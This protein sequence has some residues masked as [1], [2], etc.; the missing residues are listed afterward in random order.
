[1]VISTDNLY[2]IR[3]V[4]RND[5]RFP[6]ELNWPA[7]ARTF[8]R[9][10][11]LHVL[12]ILAVG[13][14]LRWP[15]MALAPFFTTDS[16]CCYYHYAV[17][18]LLAG[19]PFDSDMWFLPGYA[20]FLAAILG[21]TGTHTFA[22]VLIQHLLGLATGLLVY[23]IGRHLFHP[24]VGLLAALATVLDVELALFE[25]EI[26]PETLF[27]FLM[28][29]VIC[30][31]VFGLERYH[32]SAAVF[33][34]VVAGVL[35]MVRPAG[36]IFAAVVVVAPQ[37]G[38]LGT[39]A[40]VIIAASAGL[41]AVLLPVMVY[42][43]HQYDVFS[44]TASMQRNLLVRIGED[45]VGFENASSLELLLQNRGSGDPL[46]GQ[47]KATIANHPE[48]AAGS[49]WS[50]LEERFNLPPTELDR[51]LQRVA[52]QYILADPIAYAGETLR[53]A[54]LL[55][56][57]PHGYANA[58]HLAKW[59]QAEIEKAGGPDQLGIRDYDPRRDQDWAQTYDHATSWLQ[60]S[61]YA[62]ALVFLAVLAISRYPGR[63]TLLAAGLI[64]ILLPAAASA[65]LVTRYRYPVVWIV[66]LLAVVGVGLLTSEVRAAWA[67]RAVRWR[68]LLIR[69]GWDGFKHGQLPI[70]VAVLVSSLAA[71]GFALAAGRGTFAHRSLEVPPAPTLS[72]SRSLLSERLDRLDWY[73]PAAQPISRLVALSL[74]GQLSFD[75]VGPD[76]LV[77][78]GRADVPL[79]LTVGHEVPGQ[80][81]KF[82]DLGSA[83]GPTWDTT[84]WYQP[85][86][87]IRLED[88]EYL[89][90]HTDPRS[91]SLRL[92]LGDRL[93]VLVAAPGQLVTPEQ[94]GV[95]R[96]HQGG[97]SVLS[98]PVEAEPLVVVR[99]DTEEAPQGWLAQYAA[100]DARIALV[101]REV[102]R[103][104]EADNAFSAVP[105]PVA[106]SSDDLAAIRKWLPAETL[107]RHAIQY[108][109]VGNSLAL[110]GE[111]ATAV[112]DPTRLRPVLLEVQPGECPVRWRGLFVVATA[113]AATDAPL[114]PL[115][116]PHPLRDD[117][118]QGALRFGAGVA[119]PLAPGGTTTVLLDV[120]N[121]STQRWYG[122]CSSP[123]Y[124]VGV[125][126][127]GRRSPEAPWTLVGEALLT[128]DLPAGATV[129]GAVEITAPREAGRYELRAR[130]VQRPDRVS[131]ITP[132]MAS[133]VVEA[134]HGG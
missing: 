21:A 132:A 75:L 131:P 110:R 3:R 45:L 36:L 58:A 122:T 98:Y 102:A 19:R 72:I 66:Y 103:V 69:H 79:L 39:R 33:F 9:A 111:A 60:Y 5:M 11:W 48:G 25:H 54:M 109:W 87:I 68:R 65:P 43:K 133:L 28:V 41:F 2:A 63:A 93:L 7:C 53:R 107:G 6:R 42:N 56:A 12:I 95:L 17:H 61:S 32:W 85:L 120:T 47:I 90:Q 8:R 84:G 104:V 74:P 59:A 100:L 16:R 115:T 134:R 129:Q 106:V 105:Q 71:L 99:R 22:V 73:L 49:I 13:A 125:A 101:Q 78:D 1:M 96:L 121:G 124:P 130:L 51:Y 10:T 62:G 116:I 27:I 64:L 112:L 70:G 44:L 86:L 123:A 18:Q 117:E 20:A 40:K 94:F 83:S 46:L 113:A 55:L 38:T 14:A 126:V 24:L 57:A 4:S 35:V 118:F 37:R 77:P 31:L 119:G 80:V 67:A 114:V 29:S 97:G 91:E 23:A 92:R 26:M 76:G 15:L 128:Q 30:I 81:L 108:V 82:V 34:G 127:E 89:S 50:R 88:G 52:F